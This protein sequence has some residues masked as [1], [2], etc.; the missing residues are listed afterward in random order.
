MTWSTVAHRSQYAGWHS[1]NFQLFLI[2][3]LGRKKERNRAESGRADQ[4]CSSVF[5]QEA[6][7]QEKLNRVVYVKLC[8]LVV[9]V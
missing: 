8:K 1:L 7:V 4:S 3:Q 5:I 9:T 6:V 2:W